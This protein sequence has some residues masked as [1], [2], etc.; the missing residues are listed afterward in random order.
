MALVSNVPNIQ[1]T[2]DG[3][4]IPTAEAVLT[5]VLL[6]FDAAF[7]GDISQQLST[8]Q[9]QL[10]T[11]LA[12]II[13]AKNNEIAFYVNQVNPNYAS[14]FFQD[15]IGEIYFITR[16]PGTKT[17]VEVEVNGL[18]GTVIPEGTL[19]KDESGNIYSC[20]AEIII[21]I[22]GTVS[23]TFENIVTGAIACPANTLNVI[24]QSIIG[25]DSI[26][27][28]TDGVPGSAI[29]SRAN[30]EYRRKQS[31]AV[32][33]QGT[34]NAIRGAVFS[35]PGITDVYAVDNVTGVP[36]VIGAVTL[37]PHSL[38]VCAYSN[39]WTGTLE[40][41][42]AEAIFD[43]KNPGCNYNGDTSVLVY[44]GSFPYPVLFQEAEEL[45]MYFTINIAN[46]TAL[47]NNIAQLIKNAMVLSFDEKIGANVQANN[48]YGTIL[49]VNP[50]IQIVT[51]FV[52][53]VPSPVTTSFQTEITQK[54][55]LTISNVIVN[56]V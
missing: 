6:D 14:G 37:V 3:I 36:L 48:Y 53:D 27:N 43:K 12:A 15:A 41:N 16:E 5:G 30:F 21:D 28:P 34:L 54:P 8:P 13:T 1:F 17:Q 40:Q 50:I 44:D 7:G 11:S 26:N 18:N 23:G 19:A 47:P 39:N 22:T 55:L 38:Y 31:V 42:V 24:Y 29:E 4:I 56:L 35:V 32:N 51:V 33:A 52:G 9:G 10:A 25:W 49:S 2:E 45:Q 46:N 20:T